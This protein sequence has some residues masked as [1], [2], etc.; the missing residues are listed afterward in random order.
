LFYRRVSHDPTTSLTPSSVFRRWRSTGATDAR[1]LVTIYTVHLP[2]PERAEQ[3]Q[4]LPETNAAR[5]KAEIDL[6]K[7]VRSDATDGCA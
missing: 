7:K 2:N 1:I 4:A 3:P 5:R 6:R